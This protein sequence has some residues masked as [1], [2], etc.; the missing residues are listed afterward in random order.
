MK[1]QIKM[2]TLSLA[3]ALMTPETAMAAEASED[4]TYSE[5]FR[6]SKYYSQLQTALSE[7]ADQDIM[8][9]VLKVAQSQE[10]YKDYC[11]TGTTAEEARAAGYLWTGEEPEGDNASGS[12]NTEY[13]RWAQEYIMGRTGDEIYLDCDWCAIFASWCMYQAGYYS[14]A[15]LKKYFY[16]YYADPREERTAGSWIESFNF[17]YDKVWYTP[18]AAGKVAA[19][20]WSRYSHTDV[21]PYEIPYKPGGMIFF[22]WDASGKYFSHVGI[23]VSYDPETRELTYT[24]GNVAYAVTTRVMDL[25]TVE[26]FYGQ[27]ETLN[28]NRIMAY[29]EYGAYSTPAEKEITAEETSF[30]WTRGSEEGIVVK[31][32][33]ESKQVLLTADS[34]FFDSNQ[35]WS[36]QL[37]LRYGDVIIGA[38]LLDYLPDGENI[39]TLEFDDGTLEIHITITSPLIEAENTTFAWKRDSEEGITVN[40]NSTS[41]SVTIY[42][43]GI[44]AKSKTGE[45]SVKEGAVTLSPRLLNRLKNGENALSLV[46]EDG[47][48]ILRITVYVNGWQ[49]EEGAWYYYN[50]DGTKKTGWLSDGGKWYYLSGSGDM[51]T[52]WLQWK[53]GWYYLN[54]NGTMATGWKQ[55]DGDWY[56]FRKDGSAAKCEWVNGYWIGKGSTWKYAPIG[57]WHKGTKGWWFG[58]TSG[59][60]AK[61]STY[62]ING[63]S[64]TFDRNGYLIE[65]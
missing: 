3:L 58:D 5:E 38:P 25:D 31:T 59:W 19:Y 17:D 60:Y 9:R 51:Q 29:A 36:S 1:K 50:E 26:S 8:T 18:T 11:M 55:I 44:T 49:K 28:A 47:G 54:P 34:G 20:N 16:S 7:S 21:D 33:S 22:S 41:S 42:G 45:V 6:G 46:L 48:V 2:I 30:T 4:V 32:D 57:S 37:I 39:I 13:T 24:N 40:T 23:V 43:E 12:G 35:T 14:E 27:V 15:D 53:G 10:G 61:G 63:V 62:I 65:Q 64:Y 56:Y 52:G